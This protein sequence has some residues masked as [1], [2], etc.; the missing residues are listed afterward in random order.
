M[1]TEGCLYAGYP[2]GV[3]PPKTGKNN[4]K[5]TRFLLNLPNCYFRMYFRRMLTFLSPFFSMFNR[6][7]PVPGLTGVGFDVPGATP[8]TGVGGNIPGGS[9]VVVPGATGASLNY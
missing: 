6:M 2:G 1:V 3:K 7:Y 5:N 9:A 8:G 4:P